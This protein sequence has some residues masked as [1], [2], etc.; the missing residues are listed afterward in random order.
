M[1]HGLF[2]FKAKKQLAHRGTG[3]LGGPFHRRRGATSG[4]AAGPRGRKVFYQRV[5]EVFV[6]FLCGFLEF[7]HGFL[8]WCCIWVQCGLRWLC[9]Y[10]IVFWFCMGF[11]WTCSWFSQVAVKMTT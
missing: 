2:L 5:D 1:K 10:W 8:H 4:F 7:Y 9:C 6:L 11:T 3:L